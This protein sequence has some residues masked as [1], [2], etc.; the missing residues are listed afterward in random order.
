[1]YKVAIFDLDGT[2]LNTIS[3]L[4]GLEINQPLPVHLEGEK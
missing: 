3:D 4:D 1:M 2:L